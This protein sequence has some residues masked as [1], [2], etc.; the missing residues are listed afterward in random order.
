MD[1]SIRTALGIKDT[2]LELDTNTKE[3]SIADH[4]DYIVVHLVQSYPMHCPHCG[5][6]MY[7]NGIK[8][9]N[10]H[11]ADLHYK[12]TVWSI[13]KQKY[14]CPASPQCPQTVTKLA[15][16]EDVQYRH[17]I[18]TSIKQRI[19]M[20]LVKN[21]SQT[22]IAD[23]FSVSDWTVRRVINHLDHV[24]KPNY[25]WLPRHIAFDDFHS[26]RF[27]PSGM[28]MILV[29]IENHRT[30][31]IIL[32]RR[33]SF[34]RNYF[35]RYSHRA[36]LAVQTV[37][38][39]LY[40]PYRRLIQELFPH[41]LIIADHFHVVAQAYRALNQTRIKVMNRAGKSSR[42]WRALKHF[43]K[44]LLT[45]SALLKYDNFWRRR[46]FGYAQLTDIEVIHRLLA[47]DDE[48]KQA[49][50]YYQDLILAVNHRSKSA[51]N[52][53]LAIK[54]TA[55]PQAFQKVQRT[56]RTHRQEIIASFKYDHYTNGP[57]EGTNNKIKVIKRTAYG[58]RNFFHFRVRILI[59]LPNS[60]IAINWHNKTAHVQGQARAA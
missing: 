32:S 47:F 8:I 36:R 55:L 37:T 34:L 26:G 51:L 44:L 2:H 43:W 14:I 30:L 12:P 57:V 29:N 39:D 16:V 18:A 41:A 11:G 21:E 60:Y 49:Y 45:P 3:D 38:V 19:M 52:Q 50:Q 31:D 20:Q 23:D 42:Q 7:K 28:S 54:W 46:N 1:N 59:S 58:F 35:L 10:Y 48:L 15:P 56:L 9:V 17:H 40:T 53:L 13:K 27:A 24:F 6:L 33:S 4:G 25:H 22:D 5:R